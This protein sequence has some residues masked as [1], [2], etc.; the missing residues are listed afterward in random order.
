MVDEAARLPVARM[1]GWVHDPHHKE[2][3]GSMAHRDAAVGIDVSKDHLDLHDLPEGTRERVANTPEGI[4][5]LVERLA[6]R[7]PAMIVLEP[8]GGY[9]Q[10]VFEALF[11][12]GLPV[13]RVNAGRV[14][15]FARACGVLDKTDAVDA[16]VLA[17][18]AQAIA[19]G[20]LRPSH[21]RPL[22]PA[23]RRLRAV[24]RER[25]RL[26]DERKARKAARRSYTRDTEMLDLL[27]RDIADMTRRIAELEALLI[28]RLREAPDLLALARR[29]QTMPGVGPIVAVAVICWMPELG[30]VC[31]RRI[32]RLG[33]L[34]P[35]ADDSG[36]RSG[37]RHIAGGRADVRKPL[38]CAAMSAKQHNPELAAY[39]RAKTAEGKQPRLVLTI[40]MRKILVTLNALAAQQRDWAP[41]PKT[42]IA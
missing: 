17:A 2:G 38:Y 18:M 7:Q 34:A 22:D 13:Q 27:E 30:T 12:A 36:R 33:G 15:Q 31:H 35:V 24:L 4:A 21:D 40:L 26:V 29:L 19:Q 42:P 11:D 5:S 16:R 20:S 8:S 32:A 9:E 10:A 41:S 3:I 37:S 39:F 25:D 23:R 14:R 28:R 1:V 6:R